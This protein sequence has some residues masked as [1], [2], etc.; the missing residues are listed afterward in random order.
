MSDLTK[1]A[2]AASQVRAAAHALLAAGNAL[3]PA[4][5]PAAGKEQVA[6]IAH[7]WW[8]LV[9]R[10]ADAALRLQGLGFTA[11]EVAPLLRNVFVHSRALPW[12]IGGGAEAMEAL[13]R[14]G[15]AQQEIDTV[16]LSNHDAPVAEELRRRIAAHRAE[17]PEP[18]FDAETEKRITT[19]TDEAK[20]VFTLL[21]SYG[22]AS[23]YMEY[24]HLSGLSHTSTST[25][26]LYLALHPETGEVVLRKTAV[27]ADGTGFTVD[28]V[29]GLLRADAAFS[30]LLEGD[31]L[32]EVGDQVLAD[33]GWEGLELVPAR[34]EKPAPKNS[35]AKSKKKPPARKPR[36][37]K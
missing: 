31:P 22:L 11:W 26:G 9:H 33:L 5:T 12:L 1:E 32:R 23:E 25:A 13:A 6:R 17:N 18:V 30:P 8:R 7:S 27:D 36:R 24:R 29:M 16:H 28:V 37:S 2:E 10:Q 4:L 34:V 14:A 21:T 3:G 19:L 15:D 20:N 35:P